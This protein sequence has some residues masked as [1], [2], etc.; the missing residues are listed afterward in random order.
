[1]NI[2]IEFFPNPNCIGIHVNRRLCEQAKYHDDS[3]WIKPEYVKNILAIE[4]IEG[5]SLDQ[6]EMHLTK[7]TMFF[8]G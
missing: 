3:K 8:V 4:G 5:C 7:G 1:M 6:H 2:R